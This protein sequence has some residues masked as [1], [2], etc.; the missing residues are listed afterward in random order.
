MCADRS[1]TAAVNGRGRAPRAAAG[2]QRTSS[3]T[4]PRNTTLITPL[5]VKNAAFSFRRSPGRTSACSYVSSARD[6][7][8][9]TPVPDADPEPGAGGGRADRPSRAWS[10]RA[11]A[12]TPADAEPRRPRVQ[13]LGAIV[14]EIEQRVE[15]VETRHPARDGGTEHPRLPRQVAGQG[16]PR[17]DGRETDAGAEPDVAEPRD[18]LQVRVRDEHRD[19]NRP[20]PAD[21]RRELRDGQEEDDVAATQRPIT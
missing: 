2:H 21:D 1:T 4:N 5:T 3:T 7:D 16:D 11:P 9:A 8:H 20:Q 15:E 12:N 6:R 17:S 13:T 10:T 18:P 14:L 19:R